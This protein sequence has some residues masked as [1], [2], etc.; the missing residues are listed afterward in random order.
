[1][2]K[3]QCL[4]RILKGSKNRNKSCQKSQKLPKSCRATVKTLS[5]YLNTLIYLE[6]RTRRHQQEGRSKGW[7]GVVING[8]KGEHL[9]A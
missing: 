5:S 2:L 1:M 7:T 6:K 4:R 3:N 8:K 9:F